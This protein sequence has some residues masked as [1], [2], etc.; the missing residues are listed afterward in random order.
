MRAVEAAEEDCV[1]AAAEVRHAEETEEELVVTER[2]KSRDA[3]WE[4]KVSRTSARR[5]G[6]CT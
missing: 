3:A 2:N 1:G 5:R 4:E 6:A